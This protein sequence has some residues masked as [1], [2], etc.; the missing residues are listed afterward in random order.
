MFEILLTR[1]F[2]VTMWYHFAFVAISIAMFGMTVGA[3]LVYLFPGRFS[4]E[5]TRKHL[6]IS[7]FLFAIFVLLSSL[8]H[9]IV[10]FVPAGS[11][12]G[13]LS[14]AATYTLVSVPFV[15]NGICV[16]LALTRFPRQVGGLY[17]ADLA[18]AAFGCITLIFAFK[19]LR[20][21][22]SAVALVAAMAALGA[23]CF[24]ID[25]QFRS[26]S[27]AALTASILLSSGALVNAVLAENQRAPL[28]L[29]WT[30][31]G[32]EERPVY[33]RWNSFARII[34]SGD[35]LKT[36][37]P[38]GWGL[39]ERYPADRKVRELYLTIDVAAA[40]VLTD[41]SGDLTQLEHLK[42]DVTNMVH[43]IRRDADVLVIGTGGGRDILS[44]LAFDQARI[45][46]VEIN[47]EILE[48][49]NGR[50][51]HF[52][53]RLAE[54]QAVE[55]VNDEARSYVS[56]TQ[57]EFDIIQASL[58]DSWAA[59]AAGAFV[60]TENSLYTI[61]AW[62][63][64]LERL[65]PHGVL[66]F[67]RW[68]IKNNAAEMYRLASLAGAALRKIGVQNPR[69]HIMIVQLE[70]DAAG[71]GTM[72][73]I[74][75][76]LVSRE[77]FAN[78][79]IA[80]IKEVSERLDFQVALSP[81]AATDSNLAALISA[82]E[83][84]QVID[85]YSLDISA[86][87]DNRPFF[88][89]MLRIRDL[90]GGD[91]GRP[92]GADQN[93]AAVYILGVLLVIVLG[94]SFMC[95]LVPLTLSADRTDLET[96]APFFVLFGA[97]GLGYLLIEIAQMQRLIIFLGHPT[98]ALSVV[99]FVLLLS[100]GLGS[101]LTQRFG[102]AESAERA[103]LAF[104]ALLVAV[105]LVG[106][107]TPLAVQALDGAG[108]HARIALAV[109]L[110]FPIG[111]VM[112]FPFPIGMRL[113]SSRSSSLTPWLWGINGAASVTASVLAVAIALW[114]GISAAY[115]SGLASYFIA[116]LAFS[117]ALKAPART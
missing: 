96:G 76:I 95:I 16:A 35:S 75:T 117:R 4:P 80:A 107:A 19:L 56:R 15:F 7:A 109:V 49:V 13:G 40:T 72:P 115:W 100:S 38:F 37:E 53:G 85:G 30:R 82:S 3:I 12:R 22:P 11:L 94:L 8:G 5:R 88:F 62:T 104:L 79:D 50:F 31:G 84:Q 99:L 114:F 33:E 41:F 93:L 17:A 83:Y 116:T 20:D 47:D 87:T 1:I 74:G 111:L 61:E 60:L 45:V 55:F 24:A 105:A 70:R 89:H 73:G 101:Y 2:S 14:M 42:F 69:R 81:R 21:G 66:T 6:A 67:S 44:A 32:I 52:T 64:F 18:G 112:G 110:L 9:L 103:R 58:I 23:F 29:L 71:P 102:A 46:G 34:V 59:T 68:H 90:L 98:Y 28:R 51:A 54:H 36:K 97:I 78:S 106:W 43:H 92:A 25:G 57:Q 86:P 91:G 48:A 77:P 10:P 65:K 108:M 63:T 27:I 26:L 39:S 113:A